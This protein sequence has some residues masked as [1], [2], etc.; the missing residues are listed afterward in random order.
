MNDKEKKAQIRAMLTSVLLHLQSQG[1]GHRCTPVIVQD[2][3]VF[4]EHI[5]DKPVS[6]TPDTHVHTEMYELANQVQNLQYRLD[7][8]FA[9]QRS[10]MQ[11]L[12]R[13][14][15]IGQDTARL[16]QLVTTLQSQIDTTK[17]VLDKK[18]AVFWGTI[19]DK[20]VL[21]DKFV[22]VLPKGT[23]GQVLTRTSNGYE[24]TDVVSYVYNVGGSPTPTPPTIT[25][26]ILW[27]DETED[28][29]LWGGASDDALVWTDT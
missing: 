9:K 19:Q 28:Y 17:N 1:G 26:P 16:R 15:K 7:T 21:L 2:S 10:V 23:P 4:W 13:V 29:I 27:G 3:P 20:P 22:S 5:K 14:H 6:F 18:Q 12:D 24:W 11:E 25:N 8:L